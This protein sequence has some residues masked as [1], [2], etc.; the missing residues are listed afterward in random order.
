MVTAPNETDQDAGVAFLQAA[1]RTGAVSSTG[2]ARVYDA[3]Q[4]ARPGRGND[5]AVVISEWVDG[6][7]LDQHLARVGPLAAPDA[8]DVLRQA[9]DALTAVHAAGLV[10]GRLHPGNVLMIPGG[11]VRVTD[12]QVAA[13]LHATVGTSAAADTRALAGV[14]Y[15]LVTGRWPA[16]ATG[17]PGGTLPP[18]PLTDGR[19]LAA[20]QLR[21]GIPRALDSVITRGLDPSR[22]PTLPPLS[23]PGALADAAELAVQEARDARIAATGPKGPSRLRRAVPWLLALAFVSAVGVGGWLLGLTVGNLPRRSDG[24]DAIVTTT[25]PPSPGAPAAKVLDLTRLQIRDFDPEGDG[26]E[27]SDQVHNATDGAAT[28]TWATSLYRTAQ[29]G[30]L[31]KGVGL[32]LDLGKPT[33]LTTVQVGFSAP[34]ANVELRT[35]LEAPQDATGMSVVATATKGA[36]VATLKPVAGTRGRYV[37][38]WVTSLPK[39]GSGYRVGISELRITS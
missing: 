17:L 36:Q 18:A 35:S 21:A 29:F 30:S 39:D 31:K 25:A 37:L 23:T 14:L 11:R 24:V 34:G 1:A 9:A 33:T 16:G 20:R 27:N 7:P 38:I 26:T 32:L 13:A 5:V 22:V 19:P 12:V 6:E 10:H 2:V 8:A 4:E 28:T 3:V 15:A